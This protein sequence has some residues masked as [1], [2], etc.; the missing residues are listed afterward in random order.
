MPKKGHTPKFCETLIIFSYPKRLKNIKLH[1]FESDIDMI[2][3]YNI[4]FNNYL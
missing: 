2:Q 1:S 3:P 4:F